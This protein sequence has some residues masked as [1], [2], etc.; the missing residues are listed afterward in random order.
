MANITL[1]KSPYLPHTHC[2]HKNRDPN[3]YFKRSS[4]L[5]DTVGNV[6]KQQV[7]THN[8]HNASSFPSRKMSIQPGTGSL[9]RINLILHGILVHPKLCVMTISTVYFMDWRIESLFSGSTMSRSR[10][11]IQSTPS[12]DFKLLSKIIV[13][14]IM[15]VLSRKSI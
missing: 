4:L 7:K 14:K 12:I 13:C 6:M 1:T 8:S 10:A 3:Q 11:L 9:K 5:L 2:C 15:D